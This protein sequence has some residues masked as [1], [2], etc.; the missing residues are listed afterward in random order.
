MKAITNMPATPIQDEHDPL[1][2]PEFD[3]LV[4]NQTIPIS[5]RHNLILQILV[6]QRPL[7]Y[8]NKLCRTSAVYLTYTNHRS[9][10]E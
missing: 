9:Q 5:E 4:D 1:S 2:L 3:S 10:S 6:A 7:Q 8:L